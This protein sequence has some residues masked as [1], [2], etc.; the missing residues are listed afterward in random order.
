MEIMGIGS[1]AVITVLC[2]L[3]GMTVKGVLDFYI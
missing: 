2:Y 3:L 1:V